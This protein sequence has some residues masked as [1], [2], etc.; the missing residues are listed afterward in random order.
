M[1]FYVPC[2][3]VLM[4]AGAIVGWL[5]GLYCGRRIGLNLARAEA[6]K[7]DWWDPARDGCL[8]E[9]NWHHEDCACLHGRNAEEVRRG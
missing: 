4:G 1:T 7:R 3:D 2:A 6:L 5:W 9:L 8:P